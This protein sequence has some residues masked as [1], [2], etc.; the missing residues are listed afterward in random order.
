MTAALTEVQVYNH[1]KDLPPTATLLLD[2]AERRHIEFGA[3][4]LANLIDHVHGREPHAHQVRIFVLQRRGRA[5]AVL[6]TVAQTGVLGREV[7]ALAN[8]YT[9]LFAPALD[10]GITAEDLLPLTQALRRTGQGVAVYRF[11][12]M[13][14]HSPEFA[15]LTRSLRLA[16]LRPY[17]YFAF[18]NWYE[19]VRQSWADYLKDRNSQVRN[20]IKRNAKKFAA[21]GGRLEVIQGAERLEQGLAAYQAVYAKSWKVPEPY[22]DFV[23]GLIRLCAQRGWLRLG[24]AW[25]GADAVAAQIWIVAN[26]RA[27]IFKLAY[28][29]AYKSLAPG[30]LLTALL[31]EQVI[32]TD[33]V[34]EIDY[35]IGDDAYKAAWM[36]QRRERFGLIAYDPLTLRGLLGLARQIAGNARRRLHARPASKPVNP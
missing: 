5:L 20:T 17:E 19:P 23:P 36:S 29:E 35:L 24:V 27:D 33:K 4:W 30:T 22:P 3:D 16:G 12:P 15:T 8:F 9:A 11:A 26:G 13:D 1:P 2:R 25:L 7:S 10:D 32:D 31:M 21:E 34:C 28:D 6:P 18:G 14:P